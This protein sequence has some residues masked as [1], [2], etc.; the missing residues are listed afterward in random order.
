MKATVYIDGDE[1]NLKQ[2]EVALLKRGHEEYFEFTKTA[3]TY[4]SWCHFHWAL[5]ENI[6]RLVEALPPKTSVS[7][8]M[9]RL[10]DLGLSLEHDPQASEPS[11]SHLAA[12]AFW[13]YV[14]SLGLAEFSSHNARLPDPVKRVQAYIRQNYASDINLCQLSEIAFVTPEH[15]T[16]LFGS[17][18]G[19][20]PIR[21]LWQVRVQTGVSYLKHTGLTVEKIAFKCGF[22]TAAHFS[23]CVKQDEG[24]TPTAIRAQHW[25][26]R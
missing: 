14:S 3:K 1:Y 4:H 13:E 19:I 5:P 23:R 21:Y 8:R 9:E 22:K 18:L 15:L 20:S 24:R 10:V 11:L 25:Q 7:N 12:A 6:N 17:C 16:R 26:Q 2:G